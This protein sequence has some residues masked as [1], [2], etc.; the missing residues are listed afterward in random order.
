MRETLFLEQARAGAKGGLL[1]KEEEQQAPEEFDEDGNP[2]EVTQAPEQPKSP[3]APINRKEEKEFQK[4]W[5]GE[6]REK[7]QKARLQRAEETEKKMRL[8]QLGA[9]NP[10]V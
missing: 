5:E 2:L 10:N 6:E 3:N 4:L 8:E 9:K 1:P 7:R